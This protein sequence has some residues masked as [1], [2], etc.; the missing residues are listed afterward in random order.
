[1]FSIE[2]CKYFSRRVIAT[3]KEQS[4]DAPKA[5]ANSF[6]QQFRPS[7]DVYQHHLQVKKTIARSQVWHLQAVLQLLGFLY[8]FFV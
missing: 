7:D 2:I 1:M 5:S 4:Q 8:Y 6:K 3:L